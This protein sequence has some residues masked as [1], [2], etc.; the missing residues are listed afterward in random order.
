MFFIGLLNLHGRHKRDVSKGGSEIK[1]ELIFLDF[2]VFSFTE[3]RESKCPFAPPQLM[4][5]IILMTEKINY[6]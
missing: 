6:K 2:S 3:F 1:I 4:L 5:M